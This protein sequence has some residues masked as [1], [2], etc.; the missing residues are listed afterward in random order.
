MG[1]FGEWSCYS[2]IW[3]TVVFCT[4]NLCLYIDV[5]YWYEMDVWLVA[6]V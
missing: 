3:T 6:R 5:P 4:W 1:H 2:C